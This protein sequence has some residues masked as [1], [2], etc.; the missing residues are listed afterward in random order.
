MIIDN[1]SQLNKRLRSQYGSFV[2]S[3]VYFN[4]YH[5]L[6]K[7]NYNRT[8]YFNNYIKSYLNNIKVPFIILSFPKYRNFI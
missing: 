8:I 7:Y 3:D 2:T 4:F 6:L 5:R 1:I